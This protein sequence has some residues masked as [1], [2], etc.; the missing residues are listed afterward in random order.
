M[1]ATEDTTTPTQLSTRIVPARSQSASWPAL[2]IFAA[3]YRQ[4]RS[5][6]RR[7]RRSQLL[8]RE[9]QTANIKRPRTCRQLPISKPC[10][11]VYHR[12]SSKHSRPTWTNCSQ[13]PFTLRSACGRS[14][15]P[16]SRRRIRICFPRSQPRNHCGL[17]PWHTDRHRVAPLKRQSSARGASGSFGN[18]AMTPQLIAPM[19]QLPASR[20]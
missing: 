5:G 11:P 18:G 10:Q 4:R 15:T 8:P 3:R 13:I 17:P 16:A 6:G 19:A 7:H 2:I 14:F 1:K 12:R 20:H 9:D